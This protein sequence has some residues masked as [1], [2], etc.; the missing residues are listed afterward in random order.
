MTIGMC[1]RRWRFKGMWA[2]DTRICRCA[3]AN[4]AIL[5]K[6]KENFP[7]THS[8]ISVCICRTGVWKTVQFLF[9]RTDAKTL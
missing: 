7:P 8:T 2:R 3:K 1:F 4:R 5:P 9:L 6:E